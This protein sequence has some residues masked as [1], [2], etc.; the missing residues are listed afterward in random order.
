MK[1]PG[2]FSLTVFYLSASYILFAAA[3]DV[4]QNV[5]LL[6]EE[7]DNIFHLHRN[8]KS[9]AIIEID[10]PWP[11]KRTDMEILEKGRIQDEAVIRDMGYRAGANVVQFLGMRHSSKTYTNTKRVY[12]MSYDIQIATDLRYWKCDP[13]TLGILKKRE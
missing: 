8:C 13:K 1:I 12:S 5:L 6:E 9:F 3:V 2:I 11:Y 4:P 10:R 7:R